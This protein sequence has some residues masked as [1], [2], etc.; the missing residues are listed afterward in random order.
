MD[1]GYFVEKNSD[2]R[3]SYEGAGENDS[4]PMFKIANMI[5]KSLIMGLVVA[6]LLVI[7]LS[8]LRTKGLSTFRGYSGNK[9]KFDVGKAMKE[10]NDLQSRMIQSAKSKIM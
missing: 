10:F 7:I 8:A 4:S 9:S 1:S 6:A 2:N 5:P 3:G